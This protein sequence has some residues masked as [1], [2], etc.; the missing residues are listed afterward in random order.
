MS[1]PFNTKETKEKT[2]C[3]QHIYKEY[4]ADKS[5]L[6]LSLEHKACELMT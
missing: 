2:E 6:D 1:M 3:R 5:Q 4:N